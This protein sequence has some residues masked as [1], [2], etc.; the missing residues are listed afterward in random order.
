MLLIDMHGE[1][2]RITELQV[3]AHSYYVRLFIKCDSTKKS[4]FTTQKDVVRIQ[5]KKFGW[6]NL[7]SYF[8]LML[9]IQFCAFENIPHHYL[10]LDSKTSNK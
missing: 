6:E 1:L 9:M 10:I 4:L 8:M 3:I 7:A 5:S 2:C